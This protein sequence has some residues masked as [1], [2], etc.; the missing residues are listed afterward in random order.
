MQWEMHS[1]IAH[2]SFISCFS[3]LLKELYLRDQLLGETSKVE[4]DT[5]QVLFYFPKGFAMRL[6]AQAL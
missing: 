3:C 6:D 1:R 4:E 2:F 5:S